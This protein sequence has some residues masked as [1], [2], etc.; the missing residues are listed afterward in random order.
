MVSYWRLKHRSEKEELTVQSGGRFPCTLRWPCRHRPGIEQLRIQSRP[1]LKQRVARE[2]LEKAEPK[3]NA[4]NLAAPLRLELECSPARATITWHERSDQQRHGSQIELTIS[5]PV[6]A[7]TACFDAVSEGEA[8][9]RA[10]SELAGR[11]ITYR[12]SRRHKAPC[13]QCFQA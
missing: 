2:T 1:C 13:Q 3:A 9:D 4:T 8:S 6:K 5:E 10:F 11:I 7:L 12:W